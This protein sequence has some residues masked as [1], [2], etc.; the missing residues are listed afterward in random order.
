MRFLTAV[1]FYKKVRKV[2]YGS[3]ISE[4]KAEYS[5]KKPEKNNIL[6]YGND[7]MN[8]VQKT[9]KKIMM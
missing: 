5:A 4:P 8:S 7:V 2:E 1:L 6:I 9:F 3:K